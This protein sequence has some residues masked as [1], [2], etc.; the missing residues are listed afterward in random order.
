VVRGGGGSG[1]D[2]LTALD[3]GGKPAVDGPGLYAFGALRGPD[4]DYEMGSGCG[5]QH[6]LHCVLCAA[7]VLCVVREEFLDP[8]YPLVVVTTAKRRVSAFLYA[9]WY[10]A[11][12]LYTADELAGML[13]EAGFSAIKAYS[14]D[15]QD[16]I[17]CGIKV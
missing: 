1:R 6:R 3:G 9:P 10:F 8:D 2:G 5:I 7:L 17:D 16:L 13:C 12:A 15:A 11:L 4:V 14:H